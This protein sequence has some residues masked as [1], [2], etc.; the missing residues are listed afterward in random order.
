MA[1]HGYKAHYDYVDLTVEQRQGRWRLI[2]RDQR[3]AE[4]IVHEDEFS[5]AEDAKDAALAFAQH[6]INVAHNDTLML[7]SVITW[8]EF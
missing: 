1:A 5:T 6:H 4:D 7:R 3:H 8:H 2:L